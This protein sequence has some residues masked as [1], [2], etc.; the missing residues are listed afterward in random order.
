[1]IVLLHVSK[2]CSLHFYKIGVLD[3]QFFGCFLPFF[4]SG[5]VVCVIVV[6]LLGFFLFVILFIVAILCSEFQSMVSSSFF[7]F[8]FNVL[9]LF[10][11]VQVLS[12]SELSETKPARQSQIQYLQK[13]VDE[14]LGMYEVLINEDSTLKMMLNQMENFKLN[15]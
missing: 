13:N 5:F 2:T 10:I 11:V 9:C 15:Y 3:F 6:E 7:T 4:I 12:V 1:M 8:S 14:A